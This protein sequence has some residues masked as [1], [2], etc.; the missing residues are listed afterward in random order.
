MDVLL[1]LTLSQDAQ[2]C[3]QA[4]ILL[5]HMIVEHHRCLQRNMA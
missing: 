1:P 5:S 3:R 2:R 4:A